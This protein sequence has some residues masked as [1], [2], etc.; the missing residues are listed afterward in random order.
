M[1]HNS[2]EYLSEFLL[3]YSR[4]ADHI[5]LIDHDST[6][7]FRALSLPH[8]SVVRSNHL[9]Q[10]QA[11]CTNK[12]IEHFDIANTFDWLFVLDIDEFL[13]FAT[14]QEI[15]TFVGRHRSHDA[16]HFY[17]TNGTPFQKD[18]EK[19]ESLMDCDDIRFFNRDSIN[20]AAC[21]NLVR[22]DG[23]FLVRA[24]A[25]HIGYK[26]APWYFRIPKLT[27]R[28]NV[29]S[30]PAGVP[31]YHILAFD[32]DQFVRKIKRITEQMKYRLHVKGRGGW[33]VRDYPSEFDNEQWLWYIANFRVSDPSMHCSATLTDF[34]RVSLFETLDQDRCVQLRA[35]IKKLPVVERPLQSPEER[36][37]LS[38]K[39]DETALADNMR[40]FYIDDS[41]EILCV[42]PDLKTNESRVRVHAT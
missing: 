36:T 28:L 22:M 10:F 41:N 13:P 42:D 16:V 26:R 20:T 31:L 6:R 7:D 35:A 19:P 39:R 25:H 30:V 18:A 8:V 29:R 27:G 34:E 15:D 24:G 33:V 32:R 4:L 14:R 5:F 2:Y 38:F 17:W 40:W 12:V 11:E 37:Y 9:I 1:V 23:N 3:Y 21:V